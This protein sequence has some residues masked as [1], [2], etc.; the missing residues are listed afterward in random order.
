VVPEKVDRKS[1]V[2]GRLVSGGSVKRQ[3]VID[4]AAATFAKDGYHGVSTRQIAD[5]IGIK[6]GSLYFH[7]DSKETALEEICLRGL[8]IVEGAIETAFQKS[9]GLSPRLR[10][11]FATTLEDIRRHSD[12]IVVYIREHQ[13]LTQDARARLDISSLKFRSQLEGLFLE[14]LQ[15]GELFEGLTPPTAGLITI[16]TVKTISQFYTDG[17][18][19]RFDQF[20]Q[21]AVDCLIRGLAK[22]S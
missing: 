5:V 13:H 17:P 3:R 6:A 2:R 12:Y 20:A 22:K 4:A 21:D 9:S 15:D 7:L 16:G 11:F 14:A 19:E 10:Q 1:I 18:L 8:A